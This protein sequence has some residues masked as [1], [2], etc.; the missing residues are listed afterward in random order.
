M[1]TNIHPDLIAQPKVQE[2]DAILRKCVHCGFCTA[3]C[4]TYQL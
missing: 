4:P 2:A 1:Q 3:T